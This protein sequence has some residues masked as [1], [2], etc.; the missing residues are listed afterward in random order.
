MPSKIIS[1]EEALFSIST[2]SSGRGGGHEGGR[3]G[4]YQQLAQVICHEER[5]RKESKNKKFLRKLRAKERTP[6]NFTSVLSN[7]ILDTNIHPI[8]YFLVF[9]LI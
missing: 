8:L 6:S 7:L 4:D 3:K 1:G 5:R 2:F 9:V